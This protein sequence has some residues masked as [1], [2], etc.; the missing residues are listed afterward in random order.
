MLLDFFSNLTSSI[1]VQLDSFSSMLELMHL[2]ANVPF[3]LIGFE[4]L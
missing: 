3:Y 2:G 1:A 4:F